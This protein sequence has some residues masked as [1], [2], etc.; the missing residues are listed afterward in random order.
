MKR[1]H[2]ALLDDVMEKKRR[3]ADL[4]LN[5]R[6]RLRH[7]FGGQRL[8][9]FGQLTTAPLFDEDDD[10]SHA[11]DNATPVIL[12]TSTFTNRL[13]AVGVAVG[14]GIPVDVGIQAVADDATTFELGKKE[15]Q[16]NYF[17]ECYSDDVESNGNEDYASGS[18]DAAGI[19]SSL[20]NS[21]S[22]RPDTNNND[23]ATASPSRQ[24]H[25]DS[26]LPFAWNIPLDQ[27]VEEAVQEEIKSMMNLA[28]WNNFDYSS[29]LNAAAGDALSSN[30]FPPLRR[31]LTTTLSDSS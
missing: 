10:D 7:R 24:R 15:H 12:G 8:P 25:H 3:E 6:N 21:S 11:S 13:P 2:E 26:T 1:E 9:V 23:Q 14:V 22:R 31:S 20:T 28:C 27:E 17:E 5:E 29:T 16:G 4:L 18:F 30:P 19:L